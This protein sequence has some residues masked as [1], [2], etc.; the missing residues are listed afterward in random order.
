MCTE[1]EKKE[2]IALITMNNP[3]VNSLGLSTRKGIFEGVKKGLDYNSVT[4]IVIT[5]AV[6]EKACGRRQD[7]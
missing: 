6:F 3:P 5:C 4:A 7:V 2:E 1:Y